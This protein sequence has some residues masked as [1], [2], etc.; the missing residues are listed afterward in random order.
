M[1][2]R[3]EYLIVA[4]IVAPFGIKGEVKAEVMTDFP[5]RLANRSTVFLGREDE[6]PRMVSLRGV[7]FHQGFALV[8]FAEVADRTAAEQLRGCY[9]QIPAADAAPH[10]PGAYYLHEIIGLEVYDP[11]GQLWGTVTTVLNTPANDVYVVDGAK[12]QFLVPAVPDFV[13][14]VDLDRGRIVVDMA[15]LV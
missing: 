9:L 15:A 6:Q 10:E 11:T 4:R 5:D 12:G 7:R 1:A 2:A 13:H 8:T 14:D 3:P